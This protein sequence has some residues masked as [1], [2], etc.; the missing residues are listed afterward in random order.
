MKK[1]I[2]INARHPEEKRVAIVEGERL[3]DFYVEV[4]AA[5]HLKGN[6]YKGVVT[7][8]EQGLQA[9]F[10]DFGHKKNGFLPIQDVMPE[11]YQTK[12][13]GGK[14]KGGKPKIKEALAKGQEIVVQVDHDPRGTKGARLTSYV[15]IPGRYLVIMAGK[16]GVG[17]S[18]KIEDKE[19]RE[20]LKDS[21]KSLKVPKKTGFIVRTAGIGRTADELDNDLKY[22]TRLWNKIQREAKK[23]EA[24]SLVYKEEDIAVRTVRDYLTADVTD[25]LVDDPQAYQSIKT[26]L[27]RTM[28]WRSIN[29]THYRQKKPLFDRYNLEDQ[30]SR[31]NDRHAL[32]PSR[33]YLVIDKTEALTAIDVNSGR[34]KK[35]KDIEALAL[36]TN[37][38]AAD[39]IA[40]Q[41]RLRDIGGLIVIDF[42]DMVSEKNRS[43][44]EEQLHSALAVDKAHYDITRISRFGMLEMTRERMRTAYFEATSRSCPTCGGVGVVKSPELV[45]VSALRDIHSR[46]SRG[47]LQALTCRLPVESANYLMNTLRDG[48]RAMEDEFSVRISILVDPTLPPGEVSVEGEVTEQAEKKGAEP[49]KGEVKEPGEGKPKRARRRRRPARKGKKEEAPSG[50]QGPEPEKPEPAEAGEPPSEPDR[51]AM[52]EP[53][54]GKPKRTRR[55]RRPARKEKAEEPPTGEPPSETGEKKKARPEA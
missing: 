36:R 11:H 13:K 31:L 48:L 39:E 4:S 24:P 27:K 10:V 25:V 9:A 30:I 55:R 54:E 47:G 32:L 19:A 22:L 35:D 41:L 34:S 18:R 21:F 50:E 43:K 46:V 15:S 38:E 33:G 1:T 7:S 51:E 45:A 20:S 8:L 12:P 52:K 5:E 2:L 28:P 14:P 17:I 42:I 49:D 53:G 6:I 29:V 23:A 37:M 40:L 16:E 26:F 3:T 44:V